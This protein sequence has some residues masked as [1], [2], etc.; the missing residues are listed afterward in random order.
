MIRMPKTVLL[1]VLALDKPCTRQQPCALTHPPC[2]LGRGSLSR[3]AM[4]DIN[5]VN[6]S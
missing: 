2:C 3:H 1:P 5:A 6:R 4:R